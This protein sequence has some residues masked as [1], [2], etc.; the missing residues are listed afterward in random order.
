MR[1]KGLIIAVG[2]VAVLGLAAYLFVRGV[3]GSD[4]VRSELERQLSERL[5]QPVRIGAASAAVFPAVAV[6]IRDVTIGDP[7]AVELSDARIV[8]GL[9]GLLSRRVE[10]AEVV[11]TGGRMVFP[12]PFALPGAATDRSPASASAAL[13]I[14][15][16]RTIT[17]RDVVLAAG[18]TSVTLHLDAS[19]AGD[20]L[21][22]A[23]LTARA[24]TTTVDAHGALTSIAGLS[25]ELEASAAELD[26][27]EVIAIGSAFTSAGEAAG[28][29]GGAAP[30]GSA[31][32][33]L[34]V[35]LT[36]P[37]GAFTTYPFSDLAATLA[38]V[39]GRVTISPMSVR[40]FGGRFAGRIDVDTGGGTPDLKLSG[41]LDGADVAALMK[42]SES[43]GGITGTLAA[44]VS[45]EASGADPGAVVRTAR[46]SIDA[47]I[48]DGHI[49]GLDMVR[50]IVLAFG[51][52]SG[53][54]PEGSGSAFSRLGGRFSLARG[55]LSSDDIAM[56]S[57]DFDMAGRG[58]LQLATGAVSARANVVLSEDL[59]R[60][61]GTDLRRYAQEDGR[62]VVPAE[63]GGTL[64]RPA[65]SLDLA[66]ATKRALENELRRRTRSLID[67]LLRRKE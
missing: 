23:R 64:Q 33:D 19:I 31:P 15:S 63:I 67:D 20:R 58:T 3:L 14:V 54:P 53:A 13:T 48:T 24:G 45:L 34:T 44:H 37:A 49:P 56:A 12:L 9:R 43:P 29:G 22:I 40:T 4:L 10:D 65:V 21:E 26:L 5:Q 32:F 42:A 6:E 36:A 47:A 46:G 55:V 18:E 51:K 7:P 16:I 39:P 52:P 38:L 62:V 61:A 25:G 30:G 2:A 17:L 60:Q 41:R 11:V 59:T 50:T 1:R 27:D 28:T 66:S 8:T 57:R 35:R